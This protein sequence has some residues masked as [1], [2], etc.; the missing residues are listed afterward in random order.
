M[1]KAI[2]IYLQYWRKREVDLY[3]FQVEKVNITDSCLPKVTGALPVSW[4]NHFAI[5][6]SHYHTEGAE[7]V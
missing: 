2:P 1:R 3:D 5:I 4:M 7:S 6:S